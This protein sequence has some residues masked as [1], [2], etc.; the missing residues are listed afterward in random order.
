MN[1]STPSFLVRHWL[2]ET[3]QTHVHHVSDDI[4]PSHLLSSLSHSHL[5]SFPASGSFQM[6]QLFTSGGQSI[7]VSA[8]VSILPMNIQNW[9]PLGWN[10]PVVH[11]TLK[12]LL[13]HHSSKASILLRSPFLIVQ[14]SHPYMTT[15]IALTRQTFVGKV[16]SLLFNVLSSLVKTFLPR[17]KCLLIHG[18]IHHLQW[19]WSPKKQSV[20]ASTVS[21]SICHEVMGPGAMILVFWMLSFKSAF[22]LS[23]FTFLVLLC[24]L[25]YD[26]C[27]LHI[28]GYWYFSQKSWFQLVLHPPWHFTWYTLHVS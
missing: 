5:Q 19:F 27:H 26:W 9:F 11:G 3:T 15:T 4:Q 21:P 17:S 10:L 8:S 22:S 14:I 28:W 2:P 6:S 20:T 1:C 13:Q 24:F 7:G 23:S 18:C 16:L 12:S 25:P